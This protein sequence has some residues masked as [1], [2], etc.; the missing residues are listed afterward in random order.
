MFGVTDE[1]TAEVVE[2]SQFDATGV[3]QATQSGPALL[4]DGEVHPEFNEGSA[5]LAVRNGVGVSPD[6]A[7]VYLAISLSLTNLWD[8]A[9]LF[10]QEPRCRGRAVPRRRYL[11]PVGSRRHGAWAGRRALRGRHHGPRT[12]RAAHRP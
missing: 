6:G 9:G 10:A 4:L 12:L 8:F 3:T 2:S 1:G 7:T 11:Q 5:N